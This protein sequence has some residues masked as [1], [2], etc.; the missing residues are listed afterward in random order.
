METRDILDYN[1]VKIGEMSLPVGTSEEVW[2]EK[3]QVYRAPPAE[4][5]E[6]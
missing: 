4:I 6:Q 5:L 3:L 1:N 2:L